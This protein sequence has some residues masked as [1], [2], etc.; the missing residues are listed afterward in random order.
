MI[1]QLLSRSL[2]S[3][4]LI[5]SLMLGLAAP[6]HAADY[7]IDTKGAH[8]FIQFRIKHL[9]YSWLYGRFNDFEGD[10]SYDPDKPEA[11]SVKV[12]ID[13]AS[14]DS[15]HAERD[16]HLRGDDFLDVEKYPTA[17]FVSTSFTPTGEDTAELKGELTLRGVTKPITIAVTEIGAGKDPWGG[18]RQGFTGKT[19]FA[20]KDFG[21]DYDLGPASRTVELILD[22]EG[23]AKTMM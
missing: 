20:L 17:T 18:Y 11:S 16:K 3:L 10:F 8:A 12:K 21:I 4:S 2:L 23:I 15:N 5:G 22:V 9:G 6:L 13:V 1:K 19:E 7:T 14:I